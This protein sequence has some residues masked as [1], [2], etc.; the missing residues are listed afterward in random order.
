[1][2]RWNGPLLFFSRDIYQK[3]PKLDR[4]DRSTQAPTDD[5]TIQGVNGRVHFAGRIDVK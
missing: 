1:M 4:L 3:V 2:Y 5:I